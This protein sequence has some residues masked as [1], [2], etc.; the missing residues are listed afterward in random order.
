[1][2]PLML[3]PLRQ[4]RTSAALYA[5]IALLVLLWAI[6][7]RAATVTFRQRSRQVA[8]C[9]RACNGAGARKR[10]APVL[11]SSPLFR[12][13]LKR[14]PRARSSSTYDWSRRAARSASASRDWSR[15]EVGR[16]APRRCP[17]SC[18]TPR[19]TP[20]RRLLFDLETGTPF[21]FVDTLS[22]QPAS[23][24][25]GQRAGISPEVLR[26][27]LV[28]SS[29]WS[30]QKAVVR[31]DPQRIRHRGTRRDGQRADAS[32]G[33][34]PKR[35]AVARTRRFVSDARAA[36]VRPRDAA[37]AP[38]APPKAVTVVAEHPRKR[39][40]M[41]VGSRRKTI[42]KPLSCCAM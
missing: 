25:D 31:N 28:V 33:S 23:P 21:V 30:S 40:G 38:P 9:W 20:C 37:A 27:S 7:S 19:A 26:S 17:Q 41:V 1:M 24:S 10:G 3:V 32:R 34:P 8:V 12:H 6:A 14:W 16:H 39:P 42:Q 5:A 36:A 35:A 13:P 4:R 22:A 29:Y 11:R 18:S 2:N 15:R